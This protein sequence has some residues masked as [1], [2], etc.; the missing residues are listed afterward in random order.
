MA[1]SDPV[2]DLLSKK[3]LWDVCVRLDAPA[4]LCL[5]DGKKVKL[6]AVESMP[7]QIGPNLGVLFR[8]DCCKKCAACSG[9]TLKPKSFDCCILSRAKEELETAGLKYHACIPIILGSSPVGALSVFYDDTSKLHKAELDYV[10]NRGKRLAL[11]LHHITVFPDL[12]VEWVELESGSQSFLSSPD[13]QRFPNRTLKGAPFIVQESADIWDELFSI[14]DELPKGISLPTLKR[15]HGFLANTPASA[16][17]ADISAALG[18]SDV[19]AGTYLKYLNR[20][21]LV[22]EEACYGKVGRPTLMYSL[23]SVAEENISKSSS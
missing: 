16:S 20:L 5:A 1:S 8:E 23:T 22:Q 9:A 11:Q 14:G 7:E 12:G 10:Q 15:V 2:V 19:T 21:G 17:R 18:F 3:T 4:V 6:K 13:N